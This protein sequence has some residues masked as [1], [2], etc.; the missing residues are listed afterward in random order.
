MFETFSILVG[1][2]EGVYCGS[3]VEVGYFLFFEEVPDEGVVYFAEAVVCSA[4][5][6]DGPAECPAWG[7]LVNVQVGLSNQE[8][9]PMA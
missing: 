4:D 6:G 3:S 5:G 7:M 2:E 1:A 8:D 9:S